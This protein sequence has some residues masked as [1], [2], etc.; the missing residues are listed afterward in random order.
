MNRAART[1]ELHR[2]SARRCA[3]QCVLAASGFALLLALPLAALAQELGRTPASDVPKEPAEPAAEPAEDKIEAAAGIVAE[4][5]VEADAI[6]FPA[7][8]LGMAFGVRVDANAEEQF[9]RQ[10]VQQ[11]RPLLVAE[12]HFL[13]MVCNPTKDKYARLKDS[14]EPALVAAADALVKF[15]MHLNQGW[16]G[17]LAL[18]TPNVS[19]TITEHLLPIARE[20]LSAEQVQRYE[21]QLAKRAAHRRRAVIANMVVRIDKEL[22]LT[23]DQREKFEKIIAANWEDSWGSDLRLFLMNIP[24][25]PSLPEGEVRDVLNP[26]QLQIW[27]G[28]PRNNTVYFGVPDV[29]G[30]VVQEMEAEEVGE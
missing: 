21:A 2:H 30:I 23:A 13:R 1:R 17:Q 14:A 28:L 9:R 6:A 11:Y 18:V 22:L 4:E 20:H 19:K 8:G 16:N 10:F 24:T 12:L 5:A 27:E 26:Y 25:L 7:A 29:A 3:V 15:Q